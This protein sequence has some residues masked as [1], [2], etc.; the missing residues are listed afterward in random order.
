MRK[1]T[2]IS[3]LLFVLGCLNLGAQD[4]YR[5]A[6]EDFTQQARQ[7]HTAFT[8]TV[9][10]VFAR[11]IESA[12]T[13][14]HLNDG[15]ERQALPEP[16]VLPVVEEA[17]TLFQMIQVLEAVDTVSR[18]APLE[19]A[20]TYWKPKDSTVTSKEITFSFYDEVQ[21][22]SVPLEY[23]SFHPKGI[24]EKEVAAFW[25]ELSRYDYTSIMSVCSHYTKNHGYND[26]AIL[27]WVQ[28]LSKAVFPGNVY[29]ERTVFTVFLLNQMGLMTRMARAE[30]KLISLF[31]SKQPVYGRKFL[32]ID[33]YP[34]Y[35]VEKTLSASDVYTYKAGFTKPVHPLDL[36]I[37]VA[38][39]FG[40]VTSYKMYN[41]HSALFNTSFDLPVNQALIR[42]YS[43]YPQTSVNVYASAHPEP[44]FA[45]A[46][47]TALRNCLK[48]K[49]EI[50]IVNQLLAFVQTDFQYQTDSAQFG[51]EKPFFFEENFVYDSNDC[52]DRAV[53]FS[54]L[55]RTLTGCDVVLLEY[56]DHISTAVCISG[57][58]KGDYV[59]IQGDNY[60]V[61]D[62]SYIGA[63]VGMTMPDYK[64]IAVKVY[65]L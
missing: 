1:G 58:T 28:A 56:P 35:L 25:E 31:S 59:R 45:G 5:K 49:Q 32:Y 51:F 54:F 47:T 38:P 21:T 29:S 65:V 24:S 4:D 15:T 61:C 2:I 39:A 12:W 17:Q 13:K 20:T 18:Y 10:V 40:Q 60:Y 27:E 50:D 63:T 55:V 23:G 43:R 26:W 6:Y 19:A 44:R 42:F 62:P 46:L 3:L 8:D 36:R 30:E 22:F 64:N 7:H 11:A 57:D 37:G 9:N 34:F 53:L 14:F 33:S 48:G 16:E 41:K 52:E